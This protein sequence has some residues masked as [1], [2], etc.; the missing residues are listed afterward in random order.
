ME[1]S[2]WFDPPPD[3][4]GHLHPVGRTKLAGSAHT[5]AVSGN[6]RGVDVESGALVTRTQDEGAV[7]TALRTRTP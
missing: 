2:F 3:A 7:W 5:S 6:V 4:T 1:G